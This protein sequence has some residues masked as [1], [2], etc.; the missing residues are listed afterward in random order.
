LTEADRLGWVFPWCAKL[1]SAYGRKTVDATNK[2]ILFWRRY[3]RGQP[4]DVN[5][6]QELLLCYWKLRNDGHPVDITFDQFR[7]R[8][9]RLIESK[10]LDSAFLWDR[11]G[12][13]AQWDHD[14]DKAETHYRKAYDLNPERY[15]YCLGTALN[16]LKRHEEALALL[17]PQA[18]MH[19]PDELSWFQVAVARAGLRDAQGAIAAYRKAL[20]IDPNYDLAWF[21]LGGVYW[22]SG[23]AASAI[24]TWREAITR[25]PGHK[26]V[27]RLKE[28]FP[29]VYALIFQS[30][31]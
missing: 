31:Q 19:Q 21:N 3:L 25:F 14:W 2:S 10:V 22:N 20:E 29:P 18:E 4:A 8:A 28:E 6:E 12:H 17:L 30:A 11:I 16:F 1:L 13:W 24:E 27:E 9:E 5:A 23:D 15:G 26:L 7:E